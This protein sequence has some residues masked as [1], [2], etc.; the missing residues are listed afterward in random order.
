MP[1]P[2]ITSRK[3]PIL[4]LDMN[5]SILPS[6]GTGRGWPLAVNLNAATRNHGP[7]RRFF[8][9]RLSWPPCILRFSMMGWCLF[10]FYFSQQRCPSSS[11]HWRCRVPVN[12]IH[13]TANFIAYR[14]VRASAAA[15]LVLPQA[16]L[17]T[18]GLS[19]RLVRGLA[20][21]PRNSPPKCSRRSAWLRAS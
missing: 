21:P 14:L 6:C 9:S 4:C 7:T 1:G 17:I 12:Y 3:P 13:I 11:F 5:E 8:Q 18:S 10:F 20:P 16:L 19:A 2:A 15:K